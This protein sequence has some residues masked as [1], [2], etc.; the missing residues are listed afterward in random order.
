MRIC[1]AEFDRASARD[2]LTSILA[3]PVL[4]YRRFI[5]PMLP[6]ACRFHPTCSEYALEALHTHGPIN[7][8]W[9]TM[10]RLARCHPFTILGGGSGLDP[11]PPRVKS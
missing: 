6:P 7:G 5:S 8:L 1:H 9:L 4:A 10:R 11:V 2:L 3:A